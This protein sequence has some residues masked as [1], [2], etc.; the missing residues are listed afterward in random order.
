MKIVI[1]TGIFVPEIGGPATYAPKIA[2]EFLDLG[3][4]VK[5]I[6]YSDK[7]EF[8]QDKQL[9]YQIVRVKRGNKLLNYWHYYQA[10]KKHAENADIIYAFD[11]FSAGMPSA[12]FCQKYKKPLYIRVG[13]DFIWERHLEASNNLVTLHEFYKRG[14]HKK[15]EGKRFR[16]IEWVFHQATGIIFTTEFQKNIFQEYYN[17]SPVKLLVI[18]NPVDLPTEKVDRKKA[19]KEIIFAGRFINKNNIKILITAFSE[20]EDK[21]FK[22]I[23]IG[24]GPLKLKLESLIKEKKL[25]NVLIENKLSRQDLKNRFAKSYLVVFPS[26]TDISPNTMLECLSINVPFISSTEIGFDWLKDKIILF[27]PLRPREITAQINNL[28]NVEKYEQYSKII[29]SLDYQYT[30]SQAAADTIKIFKD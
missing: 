11:H 20:L 12:K 6:T 29:V 18:H 21:S 2:K 7:A 3:H 5:V 1:A 13:G 24:E 17:L 19:N 4:Q 10:L 9:P 22:L 27:N 16:L 8:E 14:F 30:Y 26:L 25:D 15:L 28:F 23:L